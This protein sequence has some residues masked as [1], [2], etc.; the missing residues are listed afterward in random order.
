VPVDKLF[1]AYIIHNLFEVEKEKAPGGII[2]TI[3]KEAL[4]DFKIKLPSI[5]EQQTIAACLSPIDGL[6]SAQAQKLDALK[7]HKNG[8]MQQLFPSPQEAEA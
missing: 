2:K 8:L 1:F 4:S 6:I 3:T 7:T 5:L